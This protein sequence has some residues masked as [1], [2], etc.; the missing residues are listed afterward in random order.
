LE[1]R[2]GNGAAS[3]KVVTE[4]AELASDF[5]ASS[6]G[7]GSLW[8]IRAVKDFTSSDSRIF[9]GD[10]GETPILGAHKPISG[11]SSRAKAGIAEGGVVIEPGIQDMEKILK[12]GLENPAERLAEDVQFSWM[13]KVLKEDSAK[14]AAGQV[15]IKEIYGEQAY[16]LAFGTEEEA[17]GIAARVSSRAVPQTIEEGV[18]KVVRHSGSTGRLLGAATEASA[19]VAG[20]INSTPA[21]KNIGAAMSILRGRL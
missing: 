2:T 10:A 4:S 7:R 3:A 18:E 19:A 15:P 17:A 1:E 13:E 12:R 6:G 11:L 21:L 14:V 9:G 16:K 8:L 20:G 5:S